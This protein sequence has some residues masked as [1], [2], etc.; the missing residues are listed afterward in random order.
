MADEQNPNSGSHIQ[1]DP[2]NAK[3]S[4]I[5]PGETKDEFTAR[6]ASGMTDEQARRLNMIMTG[7][8]DQGEWERAKT[9]HRRKPVTVKRD[10]LEMVAGAVI[11]LMLRKNADYGDAWQALGQA[12]AAARFVDKLF[13]IERLANGQEALVVNE[14]LTD[15]VMDMVGYGLLILLYDAYV[16]IDNP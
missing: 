13:R 8:A 1:P 11:S 12:G 5:R 2:F 7:F 16:G 9:A 3:D 15:S 14:K 4:F 10:R 6:M